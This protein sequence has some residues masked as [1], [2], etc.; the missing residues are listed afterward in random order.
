MKF[1]FLFGKLTAEA[2]VMRKTAHANTAIS[3]TRVY[4]WFSC[5]ISREIS[6]EDQAPFWTRYSVK[7]WRIYKQNQCLVREDLCQTIDQ[8]I[9]DFH[10]NPSSSHIR[11]KGVSTSVMFRVR[12][13]VRRRPWFFF[14]SDLY[15]WIVVLQIQPRNKAAI[16]RMKDYWLY[17]PQRNSKWSQSQ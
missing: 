1:C 17:S 12:K 3:K 9:W 16:K 2:I 8:S 10:I 13:L 11:R 5:F 14:K 7:Q 6:V 4:K 15:R